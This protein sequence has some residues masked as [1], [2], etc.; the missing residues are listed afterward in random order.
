MNEPDSDRGTRR[1]SKARNLTPY[2]SPDERRRHGKALRDKVPREDQAGWESFKG[3]RDPV[4]L[5]IESN[6]G[7]LPQLIPIRFGRMVQ[8]P[9]AFF[10]GAAAIMAADLAHTPRSGL[11][12]QACGDAHLLNFGG[13]ATPERNLV[14]DI[15]D[16]DETLPAPWEWDLKRLAAGTYDDPVTSP[17]NRTSPD[18][19]DQPLRY[20]ICEC[21]AA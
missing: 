12:V 2:S 15:N 14:F 8:S 11:V 21:K 3:R 17:T 13:F 10:R 7:R 1:R 4:E 18:A 9:F 19:H 20:G 5:L 16:L 6:K